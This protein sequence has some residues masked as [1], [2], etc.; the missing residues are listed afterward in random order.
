MPFFT[1]KGRWCSLVVNSVLG[2]V[3]HHIPTET[4]AVALVLFLL[5]SFSPWCEPP[6][7]ARLHMLY[8]WKTG[9]KNMASSVLLSDSGRLRQRGLFFG[10]R[11]CAVFNSSK[12]PLLL[13]GL[14]KTT[15]MKSNHQ[16]IH[17]SSAHHS[18]LFPTDGAESSQI[19]VHT[20][21]RTRYNTIQHP[22][23][24]GRHHHPVQ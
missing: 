1:P 10:F 11:K 5:P 23:P 20:D 15:V 7:R 12:H 8:A 17:T 4:W 13:Y 22:S 6:L 18:L 2:I 19:T 24:C 9:E 3:S 21:A 14:T 16:S